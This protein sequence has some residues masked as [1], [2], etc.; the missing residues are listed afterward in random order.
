MSFGAIYIIIEAFNG[1]API[2]FVSNLYG[3]SRPLWSS[4][5]CFSFYLRLGL[6][7]YLYLLN[8]DKDKLILKQT[9]FHGFTW[10]NQNISFRIFN[11]QRVDTRINFHQKNRRFPNTVAIKGD[12]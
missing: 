9:D 12:F 7:F 1:L 2:F 4:F 5:A 10:F 6:G 3:I 11:P 8:R